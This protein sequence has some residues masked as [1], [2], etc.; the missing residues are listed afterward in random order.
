[1]PVKTKAPFLAIRG[2]F[3]FRGTS[4]LFSFRSARGYM[5]QFIILNIF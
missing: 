1:M 5:N 2:F 4:D 3:I